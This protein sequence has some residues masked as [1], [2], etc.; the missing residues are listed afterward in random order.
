MVNRAILCAGKNVIILRM[1]VASCVHV[2]IYVQTTSVSVNVM[3]K[4]NMKKHK[5]IEWH[6][7]YLELVQ[8]VGSKLA[9]ALFEGKFRDTLHL[10]VQLIIRWAKDDKIKH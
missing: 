6:P 2:V 10:M 3:V 1:A 8:Y 4:L 9:V 5:S 7:D